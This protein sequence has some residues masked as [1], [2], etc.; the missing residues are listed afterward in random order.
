MFFLSKLTFSKK[1]TPSECQTFSI[2]IRTD[3]VHISAGILSV[4]IWVQTVRKG[5]LQMTKTYIKL[6]HSDPVDFLI[7]LK[8]VILEGILCLISMSLPGNKGGCTCTILSPQ[9]I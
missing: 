4:L 3:R 9:D 2:K 6:V 7:L 1:G 8:V 5:F